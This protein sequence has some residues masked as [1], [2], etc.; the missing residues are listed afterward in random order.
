MGSFD[1][2]EANKLKKGITTTGFRSGTAKETIK[3]NQTGVDA[4]ESRIYSNGD[5]IT[6]GNFRVKYREYKKSKGKVFLVKMK[7]L[8][9]SKNSLVIKFVWHQTLRHYANPELFAGFIGALAE[10]S[11]GGVEC[12]G[13]SYKDA[14]CYPS[15]THVNGE[16]IDTAYLDKKTDEQ[17]FINALWKFGFKLHYVG[18]NM[19]YTHSTKDKYHN[20]HLHS[21]SFTPNY[22]K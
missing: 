4:K 22:K 8:N 11:F 20:D 18:T 14:S 2:I 15:Q 6:K 13:S 21:G 19:S 7:A 10:C 9:Y 1:I 5:V 17:K 12:T 3:Y 16:S